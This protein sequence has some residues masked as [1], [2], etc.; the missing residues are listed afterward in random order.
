MSHIS[1]ACI[2]RELTCKGEASERP[3]KNTIP[4]LQA[5]QAEARQAHSHIIE[6]T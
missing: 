4:H 2:Q 1:A 3:K 5:G 6:V